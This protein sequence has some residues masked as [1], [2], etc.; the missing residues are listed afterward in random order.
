MDISGLLRGKFTCHIQNSYP[1]TESEL[2]LG[3]EVE[4]M[5]FVKNERRDEASGLMY[6]ISLFSLVS[7]LLCLTDHVY[8]EAEAN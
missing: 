3:T 5:I 8:K 4:R 2:T 1:T 7:I 6:F